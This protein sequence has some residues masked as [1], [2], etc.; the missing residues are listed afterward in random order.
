[1]IDD[2]L[3]QE[4]HLGELDEVGY[5]RALRVLADGLRD[6]L[7]RTMKGKVSLLLLTSCG[8]AFGTKLRFHCR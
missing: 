3:L 1:M 5:L 6:G 2:Y 4:D 7:P 8:L